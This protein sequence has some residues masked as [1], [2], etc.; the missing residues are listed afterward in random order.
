[1][2]K[3]SSSGRAATGAQ[4]LPTYNRVL[5]ALR[6]GTD[7]DLELEFVTLKSGA[8]LFELGAQVNYLYLPTSCI[9]SLVVV[10]ETGA[11][12]EVAVIGNDCAAGF[13]SSILGITARTRAMV[14]QGGFAYRVRKDVVI[15]EFDRDPALRR[16]L[17]HSMR[18]VLA[19]ATYGAVC[20]R[21]HSVEQQF[22]RAILT[23]FDRLPSSE[24]LMTQQS[25]ANMLGVRRE[26]ITRAARRLEQ[27][28]AIECGRGRIVV[29]DKAKLEMSVCECYSALKREMAHAL[30]PD[31]VDRVT[32]AGSTRKR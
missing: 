5:A 30:V 8:T 14:Q 26:G 19:Q 1:M 16:I 25:I 31:P 28:G 27:L 21:Y 22:C 7:L 24:I 32:R 2:R 29:V 18:T 6:T 12:M 23:R 15:A 11:T 10:L 20:N 3:F 9:V 17:L 13:Y 4:K